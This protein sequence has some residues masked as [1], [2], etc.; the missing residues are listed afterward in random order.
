MP[1]FQ[2]RIQV[3]Q[4]LHYLDDEKTVELKGRVCCELTTVSD[5]LVASEMLLRGLFTG[6]APEEAVALL[7]SLVFQVRGGSCLYSQLNISITDNF[8][9]CCNLREPG[10]VKLEV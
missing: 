10:W 1:Q 9:G 6:L 4:R 2:Q 8:S 7:S 5:E 3:L